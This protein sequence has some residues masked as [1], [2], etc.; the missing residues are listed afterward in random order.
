METVGAATGIER[1]NDEF[2]D[3]A[4]EL[5]DRIRAIPVNSDL[6]G[7]EE[8]RLIDLCETSWNDL[9]RRWEQLYRLH[10]GP[11]DPID[12]D[13]DLEVDGFAD[14]LAQIRD[15][16]RSIGSI[17]SVGSMGSRARASRDPIR[18]SLQTLAVGRWSQ[19]APRATVTGASL[20]DDPED[21]RKEL[22]RIN[23]DF[24]R[25]ADEFDAW[26]KS[27]PRPPFPV[28]LSDLLDLHDRDWRT[29]LDHW[30]K[31]Y[32][33]S[34]GQAANAGGWTDRVLALVHAKEAEHQQAQL[35]KIRQR[36]RELGLPIQ[37]PEPTLAQDTSGSTK[38]AVAAAGA[39][40]AILIVR[41]LLGSS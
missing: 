2:R 31:F 21:V 17:G 16:A 32:E 13:L 38:V 6:A 33:A 25:F 5:R 29:L 19:L 7:L 1:L 4:R 9:R 3:F 23:D 37:S 8:R 27:T 10:R 14:E 41:L 24:L 30:K 11:Q 20:L 18:R 35:R 39:L 15:L 34:Q 26:A 36:A 12:R 28:S 40:G 22:S